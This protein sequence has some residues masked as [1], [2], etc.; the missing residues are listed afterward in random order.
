MWLRLWVR[1]V[2]YPGW[3]ALFDCIWNQLDAYRP[4]MWRGIFCLILSITLM[5]SVTG[6][7]DSA[8]AQTTLVTQVPIQAT[9]TQRP[10]A[11]QTP[12]FPGNI[13]YPADGE[14]LHGSVVIRGSAAGAWSLSFSTLQSPVATWFPLAQSSAPLHAGTFVT[15]DTHNL[16]DGYY[17]LK[18]SVSTPTSNQDLILK[19]RVNNYSFVETGTT[20]P[21]VV[22]TRTPMLRPSNTFTA[23]ATPT[24]TPTRIT[25]ST[26]TSTIAPTTVESTQVIIVPL[27]SPTA[28]VLSMP[29]SNPAA[30][31]PGDIFSSLG[32]G[33]LAV[34]V[35]FL[36]A[37][38][39]LY[40]RRQ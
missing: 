32:K 19:I 34:F 16:T 38:L 3:A 2:H 23:L 7:P 40:F 27:S 21:T 12:G 35:F 6:I 11:G 26:V 13:S 25:T 5:L 1:H 29:L 4:L 30:L 14:S 8:L 10:F 20:T 39:G 36:L 15:W 18:F 37:G 31:S 24:G 22:T 9:S 33:I 17:L 28:I